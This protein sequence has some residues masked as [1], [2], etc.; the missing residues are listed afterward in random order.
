MEKG[1]WRKNLLNAYRIF[2]ANARNCNQ[3][4]SY[5]AGGSNFT[6]SITRF[7]KNFNLQAYQ[8]DKEKNSSVQNK[9]KN[10]FSFTVQIILFDHVNEF[11]YSKKKK[12]LNIY[13]LGRNIFLNILLFCEILF[14][15]E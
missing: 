15:T 10:F 2:L 6:L 7:F 3:Y 5:R 11:F 14:I 13:I 8:F 9:V 1:I 12:I 4:F